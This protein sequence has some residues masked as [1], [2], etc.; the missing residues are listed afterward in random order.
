MS[1][2]QKNEA[3]L[4]AIKRIYDDAQDFGQVMDELKDFLDTWGED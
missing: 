4:L 2:E 1:E 3:M